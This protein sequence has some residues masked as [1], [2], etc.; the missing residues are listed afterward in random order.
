MSIWQDIHIMNSEPFRATTV[1]CRAYQ[2]ELH[3][4]ADWYFSVYLGLCYDSTTSLHSYLEVALCAKGTES[5]GAL[6]V[7]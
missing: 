1:H 3:V 2:G 7:E 4:V 6:L 5:A